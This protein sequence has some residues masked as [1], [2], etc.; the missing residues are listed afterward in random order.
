MSK[1]LLIMEKFTK[2]LTEKF[3][4]FNEFNQKSRS[5]LV[6]N[7]LNLVS[8]LVVLIVGWAGNFGE[9]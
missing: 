9:R 7:M 8:W 3:T 5:P 2:F 6:L 1:L 4:I